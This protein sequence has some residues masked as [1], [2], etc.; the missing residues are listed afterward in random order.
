MHTLRSTTALAAALVATAI[1]AP[2]AAQTD[3]GVELS[4][5][6]ADW[7]RFLEQHVDDRQRELSAETSGAFGLAISAQ[8]WDKTAIRVAGTWVPADLEYDDDTGDDREVLDRELSDMDV[9]VLSLG[10]VKYMFD[11]KATLAPYASG[12]ITATWWSLD[13]EGTEIVQAGADADDSLWRFGGTGAVGI[14]WNATPRIA[15]DAEWTSQGLGNPF[16]GSDSFRTA[17]GEVFDEPGT[18]RLSRIGLGLTYRFG[19]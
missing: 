12:G 6:V 9:V 5:G 1:A 2:A 18:V 7:G 19:G 3:V 17:T 8:P 16:D 13:E 10:L 14:R 4:G 11:P 15:V